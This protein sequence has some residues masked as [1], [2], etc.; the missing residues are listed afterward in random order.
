VAVGVLLATVAFTWFVTLSAVSVSLLI[1][2]PLAIP[3]VWL[4]FVSARGAAHL[5]RTRVAAL[6]DLPLADPVPPLPPGGGIL[7]FFRRLVTRFTVI[8]RWKEIV[9]FLILLPVE[10]VACVLLFFTWAGAALLATLP[11]YV[12]RLPGGTAEMVGFE[13]G[14]G[15]VSVLA[16]LVGLTLLAVGAPWLTI[17]VR[18]TDRWIAARLLGPSGSADE[19]ERLG[20]HAKEAEASRSAAVDTAEAERRRIERDL[21]DGAQ[22]RLV[23]LAMDLGMANDRFETDPEGARALVEDAHGEALAALS[24][25]RQLVR[26]LHPAIIEDR[27]LDAALS[28]VVARVPVPVDLQVDVGDRPPAPIESAAYFVVS[29]ALTNITRHSQATRAVVTIARRG[30]R[31]AIDITDDGVGGADPERGTGL[32]GLQERVKGVNGWMTVL[33]PEGGPT[34]VLV[35]LPCAS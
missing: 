35:E 12:D 3:F 28:A 18:Q 1:T 32:A 21:H 29:E 27:G 4:L 24:E 13:I 26:G 23:S 19:L 34:T 14:Q 25:L 17:G 7:G 15:P 2:F 6:L 8:S 22:Q 31:L 10:L 5:E 16:C 30:D 11:L 9:Y 33:S 20:Q